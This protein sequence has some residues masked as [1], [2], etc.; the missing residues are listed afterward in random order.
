MKP[1]PRILACA[2]FAASLAT[3]VILRAGNPT[4]VES[5]AVSGDWGVWTG[6]YWPFNSTEPP[7]LYGDGEALS[8]Y[9]SFAG[10]NSQSWEEN[11]H[12]PGLNQQDWAGHCHAWAGASV[13]EAMPAANRVVG[14]ITFRPRDLA[15]LMT[16][17]YYN[18]TVAS[19]ISLY[20]PSPGVFWRYLRQEIMGQ[21]SMHGHSM[22]LIGNL[23][24]IKGEVWNFPI[25]QYQI[26]YSQDDSGGTY[27]GTIA[28][29]FADDGS[30]SYADSLGLASVSFSYTFTGVTLDGA[31]APFDSGHWAG[32]DPS[33]YPTSVWRPFCPS[34]WSSYLANA[35]M[36]AAHLSQILDS[37]TSPNLTLGQP[38]LTMTKL[39]AQVVLNW[40]TN[41]PGYQLETCTNLNGQQNWS[42]ASPNPV[43]TGN[44]YSVT[45]TVDMASRFYRLRHP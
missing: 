14:G 34:S 33:L 32:S 43:L 1:F 39:Q 23:T 45:N 41:Y 35:G 10:T 38:T 12:G 31:G 37:S 19:E 15:A 44:S 42:D 5:A 20:R 29:W 30:P 40:S 36:D 24:T 17:A 28:V 25:Y 16:E 26:N 21:N 9:D 22:G 13:W 2:F 7:N 11:N 8:R 6:W 4:I 27:S 3:P 18:D